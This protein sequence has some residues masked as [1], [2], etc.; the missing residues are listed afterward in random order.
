M[1]EVADLSV[2]HSSEDDIAQDTNVDR[3]FYRASEGGSLVLP[4]AGNSLNNGISRIT[5][6]PVRGGMPFFIIKRL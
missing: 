4:L 2:D 3:V 1:F 6:M 5:A